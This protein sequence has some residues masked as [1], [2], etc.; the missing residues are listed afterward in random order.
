MTTILPSLFRR[1]LPA[2]TLAV[3]G[4][5]AQAQSTPLAYRVKGPKGSATL[6]GS[7]HMGKK[8]FYPLPTA[9]EK[10]WKASDTLAVEADASD[11]SAMAA[12]APKMFLTP[13]ENLAKAVGPETWAKVETRLQNPTFKTALKKTGVPEMAIPMLRPWALTMT[14]ATIP[15]ADLGLTPDQGVDMQFLNRAK[16][17]KRPIVELESLAAQVDLLASMPEDVQRQSLLEGLDGVISGEATKEFSAL[18]TSWEKGDEQGLLKA[19]EEGA[20]SPETRTFMRK[21]VDDRN[22]GMAEG[23]DKQMKAGKRVF[24]VVGALHL[25]G[26]KGVAELLRKKGYTVTRLK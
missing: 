11:P 16:E 21:L 26:P 3:A 5:V 4:L 12:L 14:F 2:L 25:P 23:I 10:A 20:K 22:V 13:P 19:G 24:V 15:A 9:V 18:V 6:L 1:T 8:G 7:I 17:A